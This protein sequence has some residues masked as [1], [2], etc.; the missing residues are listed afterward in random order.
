V[1]TAI[2][3]T[4]VVS[5][6]HFI[7]TQYMA[8]VQKGQG[9]QALRIAEAGLNYY[10]WFLSHYPDDT[11][12]G[13]GNP[14][15]YVHTYEDPEG[16]TMGEYSLDVTGN[17][18]C[19]K[20]QSID[21]TSTGW[22]DENPDL[23]RTVS[24]RFSR[25]SVA[26][27][28]YIIN[29]NVWA[30]TGRTIVG[31]YHSNG[32]IRMDGE[33]QSVVTSAQETWTC[34][35]SFGCASG[36]ETKPGVFGGGSGSDL[37]DFPVPQ[38]DFAGITLDLATIRSKAQ[39]DAVFLPTV[40]TPSKEFGYH[41]IFQ[42]DGS[43]DVYR[44][45]D[46]ASQQGDGPDGNTYQDHHEIVSETFDRTVSLPGDCALIYAE[47][48]LWIEGEVGDKM[49]IA[50]ADV[51]DGSHDPN[52]VLMDD[53]TYVDN[54]GSD[55]LTAIAENSILIS[56]NS[57]Q[58]MELN[59]IFIAQNGYFGRNYYAWNIRE[60]LEITGTIVSN[61]RVGTQWTSSFWGVTS[62][63][64]NRLNAFDGRLADAPPPLT[65]YISDKYDYSRWREQR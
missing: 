38:V 16:G 33:N 19:N 45:T 57:P 31:R 48:N 62:G 58:Y 63:Y 20:V 56:Y 47:D 52:I 44:V 26:E 30:G 6:A 7:S 9:E 25:T 35:D 64:E 14:G 42:S 4:S 3:I 29:E 49:T 37:W 17:S 36:G 61:G 28:S 46:A 40:S 15:P 5:F 13:T 41:L 24:A 65:P 43:V 60:E 32:G 12:N 27:Y 8:Q 55:G 22:T 50:A 10:H 21:V 34:T 39:S 51:S 53:L 18:A 11:T 23:T 59:G 54:D 2:A 1:F